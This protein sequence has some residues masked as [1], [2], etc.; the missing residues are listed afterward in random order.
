MVLIL[1]SWGGEEGEDM[2]MFKL[3]TTLAAAIV[4]SVLLAWAHG[5]DWEK[6]FG[7]KLWPPWSYVAGMLFLAVPFAALMAVWRDWWALGAWGAIAVA[8]GLPVLFGYNI[9]DEV[10][11]KGRDILLSELLDD[12]RQINQVIRRRVTD[13]EQ[14]K[15]SL[16]ASLCALLGGD[17]DGPEDPA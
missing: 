15:A 5:F 14:E 8:G 4:S 7:R 11:R 6:V 16:I 9:R 2:D 10:Q 1:K 12:E 13:L 17:G 3:V